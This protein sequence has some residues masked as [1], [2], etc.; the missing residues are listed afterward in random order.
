MCTTADSAAT[1]YILK[2]LIGVDFCWS[3]LPAG[4]NSET[5]GSQPLA[6]S[7]LNTICVS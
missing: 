2:T 5:E 3:S 4:Q 1:L 6:H 7:L